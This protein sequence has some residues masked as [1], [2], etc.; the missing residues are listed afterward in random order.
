[1]KQSTI[2]KIRDE[3]NDFRAVWVKAGIN[4]GRDTSAFSNHED[5]FEAVLNYDELREAQIRESKRYITVLVASGLMSIGLLAYVLFPLRRLM[6]GFDLAVC[7]ICLIDL[8]ICV[9][10]CW[11]EIRQISNAGSDLHLLSGGAE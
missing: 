7:I 5:L 8:V 10:G 3:I 9:G 4:T 11:N 2:N 1:M 6:S